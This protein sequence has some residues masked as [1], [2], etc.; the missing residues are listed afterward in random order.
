MLKTSIEK[1]KEDV[2]SGNYMTTKDK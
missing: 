2:V 1:G